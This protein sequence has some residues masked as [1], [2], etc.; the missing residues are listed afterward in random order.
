MRKKFTE[1]S[2][3]AVEFALVIPVLLLLIL[4]MIEVGHMIFVYASVL[5]ATREASRYGAVTGTVNGNPQYQDCTGITNAAMRLKFLANF[6]SSNIIINY[7]QGP[8][9]TSVGPCSAMTSGQWSAISTGSR[10]VVT[11]NS[12]YTLIVPLVPIPNFNI[13]SVSARTILGSIAISGTVVAPP[14]T[15]NPP[16]IISAS[17]SSGPE[18]GGTTV[19]ITGIY[20]LGA[21]VTFGT[22]VASCVTN[23]DVQL[24]C[25][26][27][28]HVADTVLI[29]VTNS[30][31]SDNDPNITFTYIPT[32]TITG[33]NPQ[34]GLTTGG[35]TIQ[36]SGTNLDTTSSVTFDGLTAACTVN[37]ATLVTCITPSNLA[38][39]ADIIVTT[40]IG[41]ATLL[42]SDPNGYTYIMPTETATSSPTLTPMFTSTKTATPT[43]SKTP[44]K[45]LTPTSTIV[46]S[47]TPTKSATPTQSLTPTLTGTAACNLLLSVTPTPPP[48]MQSTSTPSFNATTEASLDWLTYKRT[49]YNTSSNA[50]EVLRA[51]INYRDTGFTNNT[52][53]WI[54]IKIEPSNAASPGTITATQRIVDYSNLFIP[55]G[56][57]MTF[58]VEYQNPS[59]T[60]TVPSDFV[61]LVINIVHINSC[62]K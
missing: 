4:G 3:S 30:A 13:Q 2:Q 23:S 41:S 15:T 53:K 25:T 56:G 16:N 59:K 19:I 11:V 38:G 45:T 51:T 8:G 50:V 32:P 29:T 39:P 60:G 10:I 46:I 61:S 48:T 12:P 52:S 43:Q 22:T 27:P 55:A 17:A 1:I 62:Q 57:S 26:S 14:N 44:T 20:L 5:N 28:A 40:S 36:I 42:G 7:D 33:I 31:G 47:A 37:S 54:Q 24:T 9:T 6:T 49:I 21:E 18:I 35:T 34:T 58:Y